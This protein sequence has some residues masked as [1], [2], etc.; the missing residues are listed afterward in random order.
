VTIG[1]EEYGYQVSDN[2][3]GT[4]VI[5]NSFDIADQPVPQNTSLL[6]VTTDSGSGTNVGTSDFRMEVN[7]KVA[8]NEGSLRG[9]YSH[10]V[11]YTIYTN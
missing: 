4:Y 6:A 10:V 11:R 8:I 5:Q 7:H 1:S 9:F 2:G 3:S